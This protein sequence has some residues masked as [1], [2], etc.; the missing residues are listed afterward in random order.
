M[1]QVTLLYFASVREV[2]GMDREERELPDHLGSVRELMDWLVALDAGYAAAFGAPD[3]L[4]CA[5]DQVMAPFSAR[6]SGAREIAF[7]PPVTGG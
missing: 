6:L 3:K 1:A 2:L 7:F 4:R 5:V